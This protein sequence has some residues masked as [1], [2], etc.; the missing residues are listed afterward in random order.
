MTYQ[1]DYSH[2]LPDYPKTHEEGYTYVVPARGRTF[3][4]IKRSFD[5]V[6][7]SN[8]ICVYKY[9]LSGL[10]HLRSNIARPKYIHPRK[11]F[12][13]F[14]IPQLQNFIGNVLG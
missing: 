14:W 11:L 2:D 12:A 1:I 10:K 7:P 5:A 6:R 4:E 13:P 3:E 9:L 8:F